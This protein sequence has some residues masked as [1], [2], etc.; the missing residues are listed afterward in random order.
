MALLA[1][2]DEA[3][4]GPILGPLVVTG[5]AFRVPDSLVGECLWDMLRETC[6]RRVQRNETRLLVADSKQVYGHGAQGGMVALERTVLSMLGVGHSVPATVDDL[7]IRV[8]PG[9][10]LDFEEHPWYRGIQRSIPV[11]SCSDVSMWANALSRN[12]IQRSLIFLGAFAEPV[13]E[14]RYNRLVRDTGNKADVLAAANLR[15][16]KRMLEMLQ[17][18][19]QAVILADRLG[20]RARYAEL[21]RSAWPDANLHIVCETSDRS[22]YI[23]QTPGIPKNSPPSEMPEYVGSDD[24]PRSASAEVR[25]AYATGA[26]RLHFPVALAS[27]FSKY[28]REVFMLLFND[29]WS[30]FGNL[31]P[32]AGYYSDAKRWLNDARPILEEMGI[33]PANLVRSK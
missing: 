7:L 2:I 32:T 26:D 19:E 16:I 11:S 30:C 13:P 6:T 17:R 9:T 24:A 4:Y 18:G 22:E 23:F 1:G 31:K 20:G 3:G 29:Y 15:I 10:R 28:L 25:I 8:A 21:V 27:I 33:R 12:L 5:V 14:G